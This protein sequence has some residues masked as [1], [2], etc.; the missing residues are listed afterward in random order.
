MKQPGKSEEISTL[1]AYYWRGVERVRGLIKE[2]LL[3]MLAGG[4]RL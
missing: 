1:T 3:E 2:L 4:E